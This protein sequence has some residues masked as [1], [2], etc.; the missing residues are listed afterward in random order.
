VTSNAHAAEGTSNAISNDMLAGQQLYFPAGILGFPACHRYKVERFSP[1]GSD[2]SPFFMLN[3]LD[4]DLS[5]PLIRPES[6]ALQYRYP[7]DVDLLGALA[8]HTPNDLVPLLIV[9]VRDRLEDIT[10]NLQGPLIVNPTSSL[11]LQ[12]IIENYPLRYPLF[13]A[14]S[15][16][17]RPS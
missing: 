9:T 4:Q 6:I 1:G 7:V 10:L 16:P 13:E 5:F 2:D 17:E 11:G 8:A 3:S 12:L 15:S 14:T